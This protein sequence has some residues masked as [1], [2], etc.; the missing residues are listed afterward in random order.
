MYNMYLLIYYVYGI[1]HLQIQIYIVDGLTQF[2]VDL[3]VGS[4]ALNFSA[5]RFPGGNEISDDALVE[6]FWQRCDSAV[7]R[8]AT[9][10]RFLAW[11]VHGFRV[12]PSSVH[13]KR[14]GFDN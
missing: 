7:S 3:H 6:V 9:C 1:I 5:K 8:V 14:D 10:S 11:L 12:V 2:T 13:D 4:L